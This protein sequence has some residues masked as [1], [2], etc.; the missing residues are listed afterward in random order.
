M[1]KTIDITDDDM[2]GEA[3][4]E[5][6]A[7]TPLTQTATIKPPSHETLQEKMAIIE[8]LSEKLKTAENKLLQALA[9]SNN[10]QKRAEQ[11]VIDAHKYGIAK[12]LEALI[13][14]LDS[15]EQSQHIILPE[16]ISETMKSMQAGMQLTLQM[17]SS[18]L[19]KFGISEINPIIHQEMFNPALH[20]VMLSQEMPDVAPNCIIQV[21]Q[22]GYQLYDR[23]IRPA[24]VVIS[25]TPA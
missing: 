14:V 4:L 24:R 12:L 25:K 8:A 1:K 2:M 18:T 3:P 17:F 5:T 11:R 9:D 22:K 23:L 20:E 16:P 6:L 10:I 7:E 13:P 15:L 19:E 21:M